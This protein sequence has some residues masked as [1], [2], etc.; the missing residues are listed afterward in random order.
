ML[1]RCPLSS[2]CRGVAQPG[3]ALAWGASG[4]WFK[5]S[6]PDISRPLI[7]LGVPGMVRGLT[8]WDRA[9]WQQIGSKGARKCVAHL[10][11]FD[12]RVDGERRLDV[13]VS[14]DLLGDLRMHVRLR[15]ASRKCGAASATTASVVEA[16]ATKGWPSLGQ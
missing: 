3:S 2:P 5:S 1:R 14:E 15:A 7:F 8:F 4:R 16:A 9:R 10:V 12:V 6:R 13:G 11:E